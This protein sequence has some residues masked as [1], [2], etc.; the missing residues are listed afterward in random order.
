MA[1]HRSKLAA[2][3][4][5]RYGQ[6]FAEELGIDLQRNTPSPLFR[7]LCFALLSSARISHGIALEAARALARKRWSTARAMAAA[8]WRQRTDTLNRAGYARYDESTSRMLGETSK[9][10]LDEYRGDLR[11]LREQARRDPAVE[12]RLLKQCKGIGDVGVDIFFR[13]AQIAWEEL[14]PH[15]DR[16]VLKAASKLGLGSDAKELERL[17]ASRRDFVRLAA[18]LLRVDLTKSYADFGRVP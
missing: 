5:G 18:A 17:T 6:T 2:A 16:R 10:L 12:R 8:T 14:Y 11:N 1:D 9:L 3:L 7:W 4:L 15:A 13:E